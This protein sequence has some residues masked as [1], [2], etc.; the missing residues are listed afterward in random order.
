[1]DYIALSSQVA[2]WL[3]SL[4]SIPWIAYAVQTTKLKGIV[5]VPKLGRIIAGKRAKSNGLQFENCLITSANRE[6]W[7]HIQIPA[8]C[9]R[10]SAKK[11]IMVRTP[12]DF[13]FMKNSHCMFIDAKRTSNKTFQ[14]SQLTVHQIIEL[15]R[16]EA[17]GFPAGYIVNFNELNLCVFYSA[18]ELS[19]VTRRASLDPQDG[20][21]VGDNWRVSLNSIIDSY[22][23]K[24]QSQ[25]QDLSSEPPK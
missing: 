16:C 25:I 1:M 3:K 14:H 20:I 7:H 4:S 12:F 18:T 21:Y 9:K 23:K 5:G 2:S 13:V 17:Q 24:A 11:I 15:K 19:K 10:V 8:G 22:E 6:G